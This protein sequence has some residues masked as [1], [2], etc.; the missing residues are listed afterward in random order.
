MLGVPTWVSVS[1]KSEHALAML[2]V[3]HVV[4]PNRALLLWTG[5]N[6]HGVKGERHMQDLRLNKSFAAQ[7]SYDICNKPPR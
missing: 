3:H 2:D 4:M 7:L 1:K 6:K 5:S